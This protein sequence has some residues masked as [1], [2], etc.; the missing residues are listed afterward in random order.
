MINPIV[1]H[2]PAL[3]YAYP[4]AENA[5]RLCVRVTPERWNLVQ[6]RYRNKNRPEDA[7]HSQTMERVGFD[8]VFIT[9]ETTVP[10]AGKSCYLIYDFRMVTE[11]S[12]WFFCANGLFDR[13]QAQGYFE[14]LCIHE[15]QLPAAGGWAKNAIVYQIFPDRF[16]RDESVTGDRPLRAWGDRP[17][18]SGFWGGNLRG[19]IGKVPYLKALGVDALYLNPVFRSKSNHRYDTM[20]YG[21]VDPLL[22]TNEELKQLADT[23]HRQGMR[24]ILDGVFNHCGVDFPPFRDVERQGPA[25][26]YWHWFSVASYPLAFDPPS[27]E[28]IGYYQAMPK[29]RQAN[30]DV[31]DY[32]L[33]IA[34][35][36]TRFLQLDGWRLDVADEIDPTFLARL[37]KRLRQM[38]PDI[39][40]LGEAW[41]ENESLTRAGMLNGIIDYPLHRAL[42]AFFAQDDITPETF[43]A[44]AS[45]SLA[46]YPAFA[47][48]YN[49]C[50]LDCHDTPRFWSLCRNSL[51][52]LRCALTFLM[53]WPGIDLVYYGDETGLEG[54]NDPDC[55]RTM[56]WGTCNAEMSQ[57]YATYIRLRKKLRNGAVLVETAYLPV[58]ALRAEY[59]DRTAWALI[60]MG[61]PARVAV[62]LGDGKYE[63]LFD[64]G[65]AKIWREYKNLNIKLERQGC[66]VF[67]ITGTKPEQLSDA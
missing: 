21:Q 28:A 39:L 32:F 61:E 8:G 12:E 18:S 5:V 24:L 9:Y 16:A 48:E 53:L 23:L 38:N 40:L 51:S 19:I 36:W 3:R 62:S 27:Y 7:W 26:A 6:V 45:R 65:S 58:V 17:D 50:M 67:Q 2:E 42:V 30:P 60:N 54:G 66:A 35:Y 59:P 10:V 63:V 44:R 4:L 15:S 31:Q 52:R 20:D 57:L 41:Q 22:G 11:A 14:Y 13:E 29:L 25:S 34:E 47:R 64:P 37:Q 56:P 49:A 46:A 43:A 1:L 55:R 33:S